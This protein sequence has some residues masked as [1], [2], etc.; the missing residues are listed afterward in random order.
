MMKVNT[1]G[2]TAMDDGRSLGLIHEFHVDEAAIPLLVAAQCKVDWRQKGGKKMFGLK[3][4]DT[5]VT[6]V[7][8]VN[9]KVSYSTID[10]R[11]IRLAELQLRSRQIATEMARARKSGESLDELLDEL[12][13]V[14]TELAEMK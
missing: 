11:A 2:T 7:A 10:A 13:I 8:L 6:H 3:A 4:G 12:E 1:T 9:N 14:E 5:V